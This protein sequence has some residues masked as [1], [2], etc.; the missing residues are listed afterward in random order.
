M[1]SGRHI[2]FWHDTWL[3]NQPLRELIGPLGP[4]EQELRVQDVLAIDGSWNLQQ[5]SIQLPE[6]ILDKIIAVPRGIITQTEDRPVWKYS[7][8]GCF[9]TKTAYQLACG[10]DP[11]S[12]SEEWNW[13]WKAPTHPRITMFL[14]MACH[15]KIPTAD[16]LHRRGMNVNP[17]CSRCDRG[18]EDTAHVL[19]DCVFVSRI[20]RRI[21]I[22]IS[23]RASFSLP[24][25]DWLRINCC[26]YES[27]HMNLN[28]SIAFLQ[29]IWQIWTSRNE[30]IFTT[31][32][33]R[34]SL[35][36]L[37]IQKATEFQASL[38]PQPAKSV[39]Q[40]AVRW[41]PPPSGWYKLN[42]DGSVGGI[43]NRAGAGGLIR[44]ERGTWTSWFSRFVGSTNSL[45]TELWAV[46]EGLQLAKRLNIQ[47]LVVELD[48]LVVVNL[49]NGLN[50]NEFLTPI[51]LDCREILQ[52]FREARVQHS[53][54]EGN[55]VAD[56]LAKMGRHLTS[57][58]IIFDVP[59]REL[60]LPLM[61]DAWG[62]QCPRLIRLL[63]AERAGD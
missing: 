54:R 24:V 25:Y 28:W 21:G 2:G 31:N 57:G 39:I 4:D 1:G 11:G 42:T 27:V 33:E 6:E 26:A 13:I 15:Q 12:K 49:L 5:I 51:V 43:S 56:L 32:A 9:S 41:T 35:H 22:P 36:H 20:W 38:K 58:M 10:G 46:R 45:I 19:R 62:C 37:C 23:K 53:F 60:L 3:G 52:G 55:R 40:I 47:N 59:P 30:A 48:A 8:S 63:P 50:V 17:I 61:Y 18:V 14:W 7:S 44:D 34:N 29:V 16:Q